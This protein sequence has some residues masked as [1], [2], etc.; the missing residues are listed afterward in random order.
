MRIAFLP[1]VLAAKL[2]SATSA[3]DGQHLHDIAGRLDHVS[4]PISRAPAV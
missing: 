2:S 4:V 1:F 3:R